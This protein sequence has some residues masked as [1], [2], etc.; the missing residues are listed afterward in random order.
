MKNIIIVIAALFLFGM[1]W[2]YF[3][4]DEKK[5][6]I[7]TVHYYSSRCDSHELPSSLPLLMKTPCVKK[8]T[9]LEQ[10]GPSLYKRMSWTPETGVKESGLV[11]K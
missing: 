3:H 1:I 11:R 10:M 6:G 2:Y 5:I 8:I 7:Y 4:E 9:W